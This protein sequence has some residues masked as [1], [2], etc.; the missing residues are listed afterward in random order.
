MGTIPPEAGVLQR[1]GGVSKG[2]VPKRKGFP[3]REG[4]CGG[5]TGLEER[6]FRVEPAAE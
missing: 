3:V 1:H 2:F 6:L 4:S 5:K